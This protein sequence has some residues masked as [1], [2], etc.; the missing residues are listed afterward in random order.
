MEILLCKINWVV[1]VYNVY[2]NNIIIFIKN[3]HNII[4]KYYDIHYK[5]YNH[6]IR[7][8]SLINKIKIKKLSFKNY[9]NIFQE[10]ALSFSSAAFRP[11]EVEKE[12]KKWKAI[13]I[14]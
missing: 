2:Y 9:R 14:R 11:R 6:F 13:G 1:Y 12:R 7:N 3:Y 8:F 5:L 10:D 4:N